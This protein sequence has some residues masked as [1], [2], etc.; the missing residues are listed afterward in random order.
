LAT[1]LPFV[2]LALV[3][4]GLRLAGVAKPAPLFLAVDVG[5]TTYLQLNLEIGKRFFPPSLGSVIPG[6]TS[7]SSPARSRRE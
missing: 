4:G 6:R 5:S 3:E 1:L 7:R 2:L